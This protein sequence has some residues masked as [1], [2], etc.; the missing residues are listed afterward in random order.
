[1][2]VEIVSPKEALKRNGVDLSNSPPINKD[3]GRLPAAIV[4]L[5]ATNGGIGIVLLDWT[6]LHGAP[7]AVFSLFRDG[8]EIEPDAT[9]PYYDTVAEGTY[10]YYVIATNLCGTTQSNTAEG[11]SN[12]TPTTPPPTT[13]PAPTTTTPAPTTSLLAETTPAPTTSRNI[14]EMPD[15]GEHDHHDHGHHHRDRPEGQK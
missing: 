5:A 4:N 8:S 6:Y 12:A 7:E 10:D 2:S 3:C 13:T 14:P 1:M 11:E 15:K 9:S